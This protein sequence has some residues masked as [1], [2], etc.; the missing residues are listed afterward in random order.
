M[1]SAM[2]RPNSWVENG[3]DPATM[4][5]YQGMMI[6]NA[7]DYVP[8]ALDGYTYWPKNQTSVSMRSGRRYVSLN[9]GT[10]TSKVNGFEQT[11]VTAVV[12]G[13]LINS[14]GPGR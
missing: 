2:P 7:P 12:G 4:R 9:G 6:I 1:T 14:G 5:Y 3:N 8:R 13:Q 11:D 10:S